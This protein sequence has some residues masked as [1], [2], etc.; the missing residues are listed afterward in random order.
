MSTAWPR[1]HDPEHLFTK[2]LLL[3]G[4]LPPKGWSIAQDGYG[5]VHYVT[6]RGLEARGFQNAVTKMFVEEV[7]RRYVIRG[8]SGG[9]IRSVAQSWKNL[10]LCWVWEKVDES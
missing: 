2:A 6:A 4:P 1:P 9:H 7:R 10:F 5:R 3:H 8:W